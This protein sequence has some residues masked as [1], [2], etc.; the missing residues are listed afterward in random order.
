MRL[1]PLACAVA[2]RSVPT[3]ARSTRP[4]I[5]SS[6]P[7]RHPIG[8]AYRHNARAVSPVVMVRVPHALP[9]RGG[10][11]SSPVGAL[12]PHYPPLACTLSVA[13]C[14]V[15]AS[16]VTPVASYSRLVGGF[17]VKASVMR[18]RCILQTGCVCV[19]GDAAPDARSV[20][21]CPPRARPRVGMAAV[22][23][24]APL[25]SGRRRI[26]GRIAPRPSRRW[27]TLPPACAAPR[28]RPPWVP[29]PPPLLRNHDDWQRSA[30]SGCLWAASSART[31]RWGSRAS[32]RLARRVGVAAT[33][34]PRFGRACGS[35]RGGNQRRPRPPPASAR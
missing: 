26:G 25:L 35:R 6:L 28:W 5:P 21:P 31:G 33:A 27:P 14:C 16:R 17:R 9:A 24:C 13:R 12:A 15:A 2:P 22:A 20:P 4:C 19:S 30:P 32:T 11:Q 1:V 8:A 3:L 23:S 34:H 29:T 18:S 7:Y 10:D